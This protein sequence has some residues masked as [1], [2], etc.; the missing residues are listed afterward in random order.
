MFQL[1]LEYKV[2]LQALLAKRLQAKLALTFL[3]TLHPS[4]GVIA[5]RKLRPGR[6]KG[7][8]KANYCQQAESWPKKV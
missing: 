6:A 3:N 7:K 4:P 1:E 8:E 2:A 5:I